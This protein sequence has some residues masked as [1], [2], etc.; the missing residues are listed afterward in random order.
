[1]H[2]IFGVTIQ[3]ETFCVIFKH[4]QTLKL[5]RGGRWKLLKRLCAWFAGLHHYGP[6]LIFLMNF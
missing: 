2:I 6:M 3:N 4:C 1:M 5:K